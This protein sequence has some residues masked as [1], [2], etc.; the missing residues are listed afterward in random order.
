MTHLVHLT[1]NEFLSF[2]AMFVA[3][4]AAGGEPRHL[5]DAGSSFSWEV[6][7]ATENEGQAGWDGSG[8]VY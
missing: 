4:P 7:P 3:P 1:T 8:I 2:F 5:V 6:K